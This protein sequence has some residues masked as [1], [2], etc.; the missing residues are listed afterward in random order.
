MHDRTDSP[1]FDAAAPGA[2]GQVEDWRREIQQKLLARSAEDW[3]SI[4]VAEGVPA[5]T[6]NIAEAMSD[7]EQVRAM[8]MMTPLTHPI[9]GPQQ[10]VGPLARM[11][12]TPVVASRPAP[13]LGEHSAAVLRECGLSDAEVAALLASGIVTQFN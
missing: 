7:D 8:G 1:E 12:V 6:V 10:V 13:A 9:T 4:F 11:S 5:S 3:E 2:D